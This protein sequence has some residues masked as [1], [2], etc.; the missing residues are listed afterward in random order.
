MDQQQQLPDYRRKKYGLDGELMQK[1]GRN[2]V[3]PRNYTNSNILGNQKEVFDYQPYT[4][5]RKE[6]SI[7]GK[8][9]SKYD[10]EIQ[11]Q[12]QFERET[13]LARQNVKRHSVGL[14]PSIQINYPGGKYSPYG[15]K[16]YREPQAPI[17]DLMESPDKPDLTKWKINL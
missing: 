8:I 16:N 4:M 15:R 11:K 9:T 12:T 14:E 10:L 6:D 1:G 5:N 3:I 17:T 2:E 7:T 13:F